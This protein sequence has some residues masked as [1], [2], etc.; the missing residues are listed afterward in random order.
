VSVVILCQQ[1]C[2][3][4]KEEKS[5][6]ASVNISQYYLRF[7]FMPPKEHHAMDH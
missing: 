5:E 2:K 6:E 1:K 3:K 4:K 7:Q